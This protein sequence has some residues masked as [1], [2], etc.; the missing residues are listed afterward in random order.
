[1]FDRPSARPG[2]DGSPA[3]PSSRRRRRRG[4]LVGVGLLGAWA[5]A[6]AVNRSLRRVEG[7]SMEPTVASG[8]LVLTRPRLVQSSPGLL[9]RGDLVVAR[10]D[11]VSAIKRLVGLPG[12]TVVLGDGHLHVDGSWWEVQGA[13]LVDE[14]RRIEVGADEVVVL[15]DNRAWSTDSR[16][17]GAVGLADVDAVVVHSVCPWRRTSGR[18]RRL[19]GP[20]RREAVRVVVV[21]PDDRT[22]LFRVRDADG[23]D[24]QWWE[25]PGGGLHPGEDVP[26]AAARELAEEVGAPHGPLV[27]LDQVAER[28]SRWWGATIRRV[29]H[30]MATRVTT[31]EVSTANWTAGERADQVDWAWF[32]AAEVAA[33]TDPVVPHDLPD[34]LHRALR[35]LPP[36]QRVRRPESGPG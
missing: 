19:E 29:E 20:R 5:I 34:L 15:G 2:A 7:P 33:L 35:S 28:T 27:D 32:T 17:V 31:T 11:G 22:L 36:E 26:T 24:A 30:H 8:D 9:R 12:D 10:L 21:G 1:M 16:E 13:H 6:L 4:A 25:T 14:D 18:M 23:G 3:H